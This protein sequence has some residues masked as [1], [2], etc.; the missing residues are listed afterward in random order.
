MVSLLPAA[1]TENWSALC[2]P[3]A[4][5]LSVS[6][7]VPFRAPP[8]LTLPSSILP[9]SELEVLARVPTPHVSL[10][11]RSRRLWKETA[12]DR[13]G[14]FLI[15]RRPTKEPL[16]ADAWR[17]GPWAVRTAGR[18]YFPTVMSRN[19]TALR[20]AWLHLKT[21]QVERNVRRRATKFLDT[22]WPASWFSDFLALIRELSSY[23]G[24]GVPSISV[25]LAN[26]VFRELRRASVTQTNGQTPLLF[27]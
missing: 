26:F 7:R 5:L 22:K 8:Y 21:W 18:R 2:A 15:S 12:S 6:S 1:C 3:R 17:E 23:T 10:G 19:G 9:A 24:V 11:T 16:A 27:E 20:L 13:C 4:S 25:N 14:N